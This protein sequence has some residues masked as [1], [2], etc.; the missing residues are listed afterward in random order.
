MINIHHST[1]YAAKALLR[2]FSS[3][4]R[5]LELELG[6][7][8]SADSA[9]PLRGIRRRVNLIAMASFPKGKVA[10]LSHTF[11]CLYVFSCFFHAFFD[12]A[13]LVAW[14][15]QNLALIFDGIALLILCWDRLRVER[16]AAYGQTIQATCECFVF[17]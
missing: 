17:S 1:I 2:R 12:I 15:N 8:G 9:M 14:R 11:V 13:T 7:A 16:S 3:C 4:A 5:R 10:L 6:S